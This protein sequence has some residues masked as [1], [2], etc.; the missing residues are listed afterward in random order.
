MSLTLV[1]STGH[2]SASSKCTLQMVETD[3]IFSLVTK[4]SSQDIEQEKLYNKQKQR[5]KVT[6]LGEKGSIKTEY[7]FTYAMPEELVPQIF[8]LV[9][10]NLERKKNL[11]TLASTGLYRQRSEGLKWQDSYLQ[12]VFVRRSKIFQLQLSQGE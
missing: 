9:N 11:T 12:L 8:C 7:S 5:K 3:R 2:Q 4:P 6:T 1:C 10:L